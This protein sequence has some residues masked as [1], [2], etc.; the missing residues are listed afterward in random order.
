MSINKYAPHVYVIPEDDADRQLADGFI[1]HH[2]VK[3]QRIQV[4]PVAGGWPNVLK[5]FEDEYLQALRNNSH[6]HVVMVVDFDVT[7]Q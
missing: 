4:M 1:L 3:V 7:A 6:A 5:T 2:A